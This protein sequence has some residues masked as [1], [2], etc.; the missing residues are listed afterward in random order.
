M[1]K[2]GKTIDSSTQYTIDINIDNKENAKK[3]K[4]IE[5]ILEKKYSNIVKKSF[6]KNRDLSLTQRR[7]LEQSL[8]EERKIL[9]SRNI[10]DISAYQNYL[11]KNPN[12]S[13][14]AENFF[15]NYD[16]K[17]IKDLRKN[18]LGLKKDSKEIESEKRKKEKDTN[19]EDNLSNSIK[20]LLN[21][22][23][24]LGKENNKYEKGL[25]KLNKKLNQLY[26]NTS[27][28]IFGIFDKFKIPSYYRRYGASR[29]IA[30][31]ITGSAIST[32]IASL[33]KG[34]SDSKRETWLSEITGKKNRPLNRAMNNVLIKRMMKSGSSYD[35][36]IN[37]IYMIND[38]LNDPEKLKQ[39]MNTTLTPLSPFMSI[40]GV[41][42]AFKNNPNQIAQQRIRNNFGF[43]ITRG[44]YGNITREELEEAKRLVKQQEK[45]TESLR[46]IN[47]LWK[48]FS[49]KSITF[50]GGVAGDTNKILDYF[51]QNKKDKEKLEKNKP[52]REMEARAKQ[53]ATFYT[54]NGDTYFDK[55]LYYKNLQQEMVNHIRE[56]RG[57]ST[58]ENTEN[59]NSVETVSQNIEINFNVEQL[60]DIANILNDI[61]KNPESLN[62]YSQNND[63]NIILREILSKVSK[64]SYQS[65]NLGN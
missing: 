58:N 63:N 64:T 5:S 35:Q 17:K 50:L 20:N 44:Q 54:G 55:D 15:A 46:E 38:A 8:K 7:L 52:L 61:Q 48:R 14:M 26:K 34:I 4:L 41:L 13:K 32:L 39:L 57:I 28:T 42:E 18:F 24:R 60:N 56:N 12:T 2:I 45:T 10:S 51:A 59:K 1:S 43:D 9:S 65:N 29:F 11:L 23:N 25:K 36:A 3:E 21:N 53:K 6:F 19:Q 37:S 31:T 22:F 47:V 62:K 27:N 30:P 49:E 33:Y 16:E 40:Q